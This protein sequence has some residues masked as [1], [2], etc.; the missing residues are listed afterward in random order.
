MD[1]VF[2]VTKDM[3]TFCDEIFN[4]GYIVKISTIKMPRLSKNKIKMDCYTIVY[5]GLLF[6][7]VRVPKRW[8]Y[9]YVDNL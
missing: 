8:I 6:T 3:Q 4:N 9:I 7:L 2:E 1:V 5:D